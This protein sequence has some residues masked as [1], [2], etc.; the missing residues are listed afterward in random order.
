MHNDTFDQS[1]DSFHK[2]F[3]SDNTTPVNSESIRLYEEKYKEANKVIPLSTV[4]DDSESTNL[5]YGTGS[6]DSVLWRSR[7]NTALFNRAHSTT[8]H[9]RVLLLHQV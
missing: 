2:L 3:Y 7:H 9:L 5:M 4:W 8:S 1:I 6:H